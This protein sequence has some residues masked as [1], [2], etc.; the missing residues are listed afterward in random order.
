[1]DDIISIILI[2][3]GAVIGYFIAKRMLSQQKWGD[4][5]AVLNEKFKRNIAELEKKY[6]VEMKGYDA[7]ME[8]LEK[9]WKIKYVKDIQELENSFK[10]AEKI[11]RLKSVSSSRR[12]LIGKFIEKFVP[13][14]NN[15]GYEPSDMHFLGQPIDYIVFDGLHGDEVN[16]IVFLEVKT[17][18]SKLTKREKSLKEAVEK[19]KVYWKEYR[20][21]SSEEEGKKSLDKEMG[22]KETAIEDLYEGIEDKIRHVKSSIPKSELSSIETNESGEYKIK[23][24][25]CDE[26][27]S[28][29]LDENEIRDL[30]TG[31]KIKIKCSECKKPMI[32]DS[33][34][35]D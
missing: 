10:S 8:R 34:I 31:E 2:L 4:K 5:E 20:F 16:K 6:E 18:E 19:K 24:P 35:L 3:V 14:L 1:M 32:I 23:C 30:K 13:F 9:D 33:S 22:N 25:N 7:K 17:G 27:L 21:D 11:I 28:I 12:S 29:E 15:I 26:E